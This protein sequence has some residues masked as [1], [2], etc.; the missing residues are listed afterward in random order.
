MLPSI[1]LFKFLNVIF[2]FFTPY[3]VIKN[4]TSASAFEL[5]GATGSSKSMSEYNKLTSGNVDILL[6][7]GILTYSLKVVL[8]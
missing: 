1:E 7:V 4:K 5:D 2:S 8:G 3:L 6:S